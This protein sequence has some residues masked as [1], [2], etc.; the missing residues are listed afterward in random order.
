MAPATL[1][2]VLR[3]LRRIAGTKPTD[4]LTDCQLL[5]RFTSRCDEAAFAAL[6][7]RHG[8]L[9]HAV[10]GRIL[11]HAPDVDDVFQATLI[12]LARK[13]RSLRWHES[14]GPWLHAV[15]F[16]L[17]Q[18][19]KADAAR[20]REREQQAEPRSASGPLQEILSRELHAVLDQ[21]LQG[22]GHSY[23]A[24]LILCYLEGQTRDAAAQQLGWSL[25][26]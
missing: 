7:E 19:A 22:L 14:V 26:P 20:R 25:G 16:R 15:A 18:R 3:H 4:A 13:A 8:T 12:V 21:E 10:C 6:V 11:G 17:A 23:R 2:L 9:I 1:H 5:E 24:P